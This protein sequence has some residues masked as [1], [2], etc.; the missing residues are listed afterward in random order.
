MSSRNLVS[1]V[2]PVYNGEDYVG[3]MIESLLGQTHHNYEVFIVNDF[4]KDRSI[5]IIKD[6]I[7]DDSRFTILDADHKL[8]TAVRGQ[9]YALPYCK[10]KFYFFL[11][12]DDFID[13]DLL[14][15]C[16]KKSIEMD[17]D[18]VTPNCVRFYGNSS[19][20]HGK[21]PLNGDYSMVLQPR[22]AFELSLTWKV[23]GFSLKRMD[24]VKKVGIVGT[25]YNSCE[26]FCRIALLEANKIVF[27]DSNFY[28]RLNN[29]N[30]ITQ[31]L[32]Y[33]HID[34]LKTDIM[35]LKRYCKE[36]Y[37]RK[38]CLRR[39]RSLVGGWLSWWIKAIE[40]NML[41]LHRCYVL[42]MLINIQ[43]DLMIL[44]PRI[45]ICG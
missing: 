11:S 23:H 38:K 35:L 1:I 9:E 14:E 29:P 41:F 37:G 43:F 34:I 28:Y 33:F 22:D 3:Q 36:H 20:L 5:E 2:V 26:Y 18:V 27:A 4:S 40:N 31:G 8:G 12:Q 39:Y 17:A 7:K 6:I 19:E 42:R 45:I 21:Y 44:F 25:Y 24:L 13:P 10:G 15:I 30:A 16:V 32:K